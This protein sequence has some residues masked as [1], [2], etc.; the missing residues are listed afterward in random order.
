[1]RRK[2]RKAIKGL[3]I[4]IILIIVFVFFMYYLY[5]TYN[6]IDI[7][8]EYEA[9]KMR[10]STEYEQTVDNAVSESKKM[11]DVIEDI[12]KSVCGISKLSDRGTAVL[13]TATETE[14][15]LGTGVI[16]LSNGY[17]LSNAHVTGEKYSTCY[18]TIGE[19]NIYRGTVEWADVDLDLS[20]IKINAK[21]LPTVNLG[22]SDDV[23]VGETVYAIG[24]PI[25]YEFRQTVTSGI[26]SALNRTIKIE[27]DENISYMSNLIQTDATINPGNSGGP[28]I[29]V[30]GDVIGINSV[31]ITS[32]DGIGFAIPINVVKPVI[33]SFSEKGRFEEVTLGIYAYDESIAQYLK[34]GNQY[35]SGIYVANV[36]EDGPAEK[37]G[38]KI[39]DVINKIDG[40]SFYTMNSLKEYIYS[41]I[42]GDEVK[43]EFTR[44][45]NKKEVNI[46]LEKKMN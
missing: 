8:K 20:I 26:I 31:K 24:N 44:N 13:S 33:N 43:L 3:I 1:M 27:E 38:L 22:K 15:G 45:K 12:S 40:Q 7:V 28:L 14:L 11:E 32:A 5:S 25:G 30:N 34:L 17:I 37:S 19:N 29:S 35:T 6:N 42:P 41:K 39:G 46:K 23:K 18:V 4:S 9:K 21:D 2:K 16:V 10:V 36:V